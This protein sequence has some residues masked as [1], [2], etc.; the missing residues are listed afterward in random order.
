MNGQDGTEY[1]CLRTS[2][3]PVLNNHWIIY[4][5]IYWHIDYKSFSEKKETEIKSTNKK[6]LKTRIK[7]LK[8]LT[9]ISVTALPHSQP[10]T[11]VHI[12]AIYK[13]YGHKEKQG[14]SR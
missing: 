7:E 14:L 3:K 4:F 13:A 11:Q 5:S 6:W 12:C 8:E 9:I 10:Q 2:K 1:I